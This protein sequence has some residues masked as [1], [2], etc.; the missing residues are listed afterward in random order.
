MLPPEIPNVTSHVSK[1]VRTLEL[2]PMKKDNY[3]KVT[4]AISR[5][6]AKNNQG[7]YTAKGLEAAYTQIGIPSQ[8]I[9][10]CFNDMTICG[11]P[12]TR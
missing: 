3:S 10:C 6:Q 4:D 7:T 5:A 9:I 1:P 8:F 2:T 12:F 11:I